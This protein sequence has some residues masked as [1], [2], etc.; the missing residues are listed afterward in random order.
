LLHLDLCALG[1]QLVKQNLNA[2]VGE[3]LAAESAGNPRVCSRE[4]LRHLARY[5]EARMRQ[6]SATQPAGAGSGQRREQPKPRRR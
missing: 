6:R 2:V 3:G 5:D 1:A 4:V